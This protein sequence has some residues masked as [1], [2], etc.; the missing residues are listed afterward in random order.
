MGSADGHSNGCYCNTV[1]YSIL[2]A[3]GYCQD[4]VDPNAIQTYVFYSF[5][6]LLTEALQPHTLPIRWADFISECAMANL[7][8]QMFVTPYTTPVCT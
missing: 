8:I 1:F 7:E 3:C 2:A 5:V 4:V 6:Y